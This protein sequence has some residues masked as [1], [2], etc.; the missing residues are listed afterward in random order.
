[1]TRICDTWVEANSFKVYWTSQ[2]LTATI[3]ELP[4]GYYKV[5]TC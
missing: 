1:M 2:G 4:N 3:E 5:T